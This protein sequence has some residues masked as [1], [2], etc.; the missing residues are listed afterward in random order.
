MET[1]KAIKDR[2]SVK[3]YDSSVIIPE[4]DKEL[5]YEAVRHCPTSYNIQNWRFV[6]VEE[7]GLRQKIRTAAFDQAQIT[8]ASLLLVVCADLLAWKKSPERYWEN[9]PESV[10]NLLVPRISSFYEGQDVLHRDEAM[11]SVGIV[12]Q[13]LMIAAKDLGYDSCPMIGFDFN[14]VSKLIN[15]PSD[16]VIGMIIVV[17]KALKPAHPKGGFLP[18][19]ELIVK[20]KF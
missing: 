17:G 9:A 20:N 18:S 19:N 6:E 14:E 2:R 3:E 15:L 5:M 1:L 11:R 4:V 8:E 10:R 7:A 12:G 16:H 13:T